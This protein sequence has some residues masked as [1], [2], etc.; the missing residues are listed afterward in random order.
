MYTKF[1]SFK[2]RNLT[3]RYLSRSPPMMT[4]NPVPAH[5]YEYSEAC[6]IPRPSSHITLCCDQ[7]AFHCTTQI[8]PITPHTHTHTHL[9]THTLTHTHTHTHSHSPNTNCETPTAS[10]CV[11]FR[12]DGVGMRGESGF[13]LLRVISGDT[14]REKERERERE[15]GCGTC[16]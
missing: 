15:S 8:P 14:E 7:I 11:N 16:C 13:I 3:H 12:I 9:H 4:Y 2:F 10:A 1:P 5:L 6:Y